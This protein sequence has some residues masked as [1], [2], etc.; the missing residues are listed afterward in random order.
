MKTIRILRIIVNYE[1]FYVKIKPN[2]LLGGCIY[3][4]HCHKQYRSLS[5]SVFNANV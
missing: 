4:T 3:R 2:P 5:V 1:W